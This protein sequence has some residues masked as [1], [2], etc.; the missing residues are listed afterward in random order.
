MS[1]FMF[2]SPSRLR[3]SGADAPGDLD[4][5]L[6]RL[7]REAPVDELSRDCCSDARCVRAQLVLEPSVQTTRCS[8]Q[9]DGRVAARVRPH[10]AAVGD[11]VA[12]NRTCHAS[13]AEPRVIR[14]RPSVDKAAL[15]LDG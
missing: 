5:R 7:D 4:V 14:N 6:V 8:R 12:F 13:D 9:A 3:S 1:F 15:Y 10:L 11:D 2:S